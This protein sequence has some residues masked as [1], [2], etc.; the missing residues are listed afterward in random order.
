MG[1]YYLLDE[2]GNAIETLDVIEWSQH[3]ESYRRVAFDTVDYFGRAITVSTVFLGINHNFLENGPPILFETML[4]MDCTPFTD[5][6][7]VTHTTK[8]LEEMPYGQQRYHTLEEAKREHHKLTVYLKE[9]A[10]ARRL[11]DMVEVEYALS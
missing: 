2:Q 4:F 8:D 10:E 1:T 9:F 11:F 3:V 5:M 7:G 6:L